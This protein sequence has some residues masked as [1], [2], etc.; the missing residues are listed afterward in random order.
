M[1]IRDRITFLVDN[2]QPPSGYR[3][4]HLTLTI[5]N[6]SDLSTMTLQILHSF[7]ELRKTNSWK[8]HVN[9]GAFVVEVTGEHGNWHVH[10]HIIIEAKYY[11]WAELLKLWM[12]LSPGRGVYIQDIPKG[13]IILYLTKYISKTATPEDDR[14]E[15]NEA[16][17]GSRLFQ[18]FGSWYAINRLYELPPKHC[19]DCDHA[20]FIVLSIMTEG[21]FD[22]FWKEA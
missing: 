11:K 14:D 19:P 12:K 4:K 1:R 21:V 7:K 6:Q 3:T 8:K 22:T 18:P 16:L 20:T 5:K 10:L 13:E 15:L 17:K 2:I 9:G